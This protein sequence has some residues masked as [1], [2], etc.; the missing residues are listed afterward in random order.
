[1]KLRQLRTFIRFLECVVCMWIGYAIAPIFISG[2][3]SATAYCGLGLVHDW[4]EERFEP[5]RQP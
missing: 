3:F 1:M 4:I 5:E 2:W